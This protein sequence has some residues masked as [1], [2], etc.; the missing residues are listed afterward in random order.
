MIS[1][2]NYI[3][4]NPIAIFGIGAALAVIPFGITLAV[5]SVFKEVV[6]KRK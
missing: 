5:V 4:T 2:T 6:R 3:L 1:F